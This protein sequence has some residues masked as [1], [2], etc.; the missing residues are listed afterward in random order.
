MS[1]NLGITD[2]VSM[3]TPVFGFVTILVSSAEEEPFEVL[4]H[5]LY[6]GHTTRCIV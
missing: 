3:K 6:S 4:M 5:F 1:A 2:I